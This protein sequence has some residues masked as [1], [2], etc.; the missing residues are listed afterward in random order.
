MISDGVERVVCEECGET[1]VRHA[2]LVAGDV[3][4]A[5]FAR[6][7]G[8]LRLLIDVEEEHQTFG[9]RRPR[10]AKPADA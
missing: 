7:D 10:H 8:F 4:R 9:M 1:T 2:S 5:Q 6:K 3:N